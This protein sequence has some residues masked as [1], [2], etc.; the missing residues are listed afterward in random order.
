MNA[1]SHTPDIRRDWPKVSIVMRSYN[2]IN[3]I[4][5]TIEAVLT[6]NYPNFELWNFDSTSTDGTLE[7]I[8][9][10]NAMER[11]ILN[12]S[13]TYNPGRVLNE[14][15][16]A[17]HA[18]IVVFINSDATPERDDW[19]VQLVTPLLDDCRVA[20]VFGRQTSRH[21]CR[22]LFVKDNER[23]FGDGSISAAWHH[24]FS[25]ANSAIRRSAWRNEPFETRIQYSEDIDWTYRLKKKGFRIAYA[26]AASAVHSHNY[27]L[28]E[29]FKRHFGEGK[30]DAWIFRDEHSSSDLFRYALLPALREILRDINWA[31]KI[32][33]MDAVLHSVPLRLA[34]KLGR[35]KGFREG[36]KCYE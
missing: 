16:M 8:K 32:K 4:Q 23:A 10:Y 17:T 15:M 19:L 14:A 9:R 35:W 24:F 12:D 22:A 1:S 25:M 5:Q 21:D 11:I 26:Q 6:Q 3:L 34:Q 36:R 18:D 28:K 33:S 13:K 2:D 20:A 30:A 27:T 31:L 7:V 29:S